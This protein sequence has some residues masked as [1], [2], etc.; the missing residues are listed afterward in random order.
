[1]N[2][3]KELWQKLAGSK[4]YRKAFVGSLLKRGTALQIQNLL[5]Q[6]GW[7]QTQLAEACGLTQGVISRA[8]N[9]AYGNLTFNTVIEIAA[10]FDVAF[11]GRFVPFSEFSKWAEN[12]SEGAAFEMPGFEEENSNIEKSIPDFPAQEFYRD[13]PYRKDFVITNVNR[14]KPPVKVE[15][16]EHRKK[17][18]LGS[19]GQADGLRLGRPEVANGI[20]EQYKS[21]LEAQDDSGYKSLQ[22]AA[23]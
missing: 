8:Q 2:T 17:L 9:P 21:A 13:I 16:I 23:N 5:K 4:K 20:E 15:S 22:G 1:M 6:R 14:K 18:A 3:F 10:G 12:M 11:I 7:S 19:T